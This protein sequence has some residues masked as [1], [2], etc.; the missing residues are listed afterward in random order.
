MNSASSP[1]APPPADPAP[2]L[3]LRAATP[4]DAAA[5]LALARSLPT[6]PHWSGADYR[7]ALDPAATPRRLALV[8]IESTTGTI[9][10]FA[11]ALLLAP[12]SELELIA[13]APLWQRKG[14]G[15][16]LLRALFATLLRA[17]VRVLLLEVRAS[18]RAA[19]KL[20]QSAGFVV[21]GRRK[22]YYT[23]PIEDAALMRLDLSDLSFPEKP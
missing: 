11:V 23:D 17:K 21:Q 2:A 5:L 9:V 22:G 8:A 7:A 20:Y 15:K 19:E 14:V 12:E 3:S 1:P 10:G 4:D 13:V 6:A 18:N 16:A